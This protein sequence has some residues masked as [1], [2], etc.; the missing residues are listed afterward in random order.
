MRWYRDKSSRSRVYEVS[1][2]KLSPDNG[3]WIGI[4]Q[5][6]CG[7]NFGKI[8][9]AVTDPGFIVGGGANPIRGTPTPD[10]TTF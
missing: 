1:C 7:E 8:T 2:C 4:V 6:I 3:T 10:V 9:A 5:I